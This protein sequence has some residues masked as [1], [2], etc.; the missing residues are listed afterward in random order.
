MEAA[1]REGSIDKYL[2]YNKN[3]YDVL[4]KI[5]TIDLDKIIEDM[6][7][8][9]TIEDFKKTI[10][11]ELAFME[12]LFVQRMIDNLNEIEDVRKFDTFL[13]KFINLREYEA[14]CN[15]ICLSVQ[16]IRNFVYIYDTEYILYLNIAKRLCE[17]D[18]D[19]YMLFTHLETIGKQNII[20]YLKRNIALS[21][22]IKQVLHL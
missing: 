2:E 10:K 6:K 18:F 7:S 17:N 13:T 22:K 19:Y 5:R 4:Y 15:K 12:D 14:E 9:N 20:L 16:H 3:L 11:Q 21:D 1:I 8:K